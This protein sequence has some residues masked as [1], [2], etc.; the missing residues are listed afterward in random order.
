MQLFITSKK[1]WAFQKKKKKKKKLKIP[2]PKETK[3]PKQP[4]PGV[5][6]HFFPYSKMNTKSRTCQRT[7]GLSKPIVK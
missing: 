1:Y 5:Q 2:T 3:G 7:W 6:S 4:N